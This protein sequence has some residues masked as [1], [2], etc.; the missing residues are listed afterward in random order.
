MFLNNAVLKHADHGSLRVL[1]TGD[2]GFARKTL[3]VPIIFEEIGDAAREYPI[4]F[5]AANPLPHVL[6][7]V[8]QDINA[9]VADDGRWNATYIPAFIRRYPFALAAVKG[10]KEPGGQTRFAVIIDPDAPQLKSANGEPV[11]A[12]DGGPSE[13]LKK[14]LELLEAIEKSMERTQKQVS[15]LEESGLLVERKITVSRPGMDPVAVTGLRMINERRL[16]EFEAD[17]FLPL[18]PVLPLVY[19]HLLS[20]ASL[21]L[22]PI[23]GRYPQLRQPTALTPMSLGSD[24]IDFSNFS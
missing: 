8:E 16:N 14:R 21:R 7:G 23:G 13:F 3:M 10:E 15:I 24:P 9:Y 17:A 1:E 6:L 20:W 5:P 11:F 2:Y 4:V 12:P 22:G 19:A 18:R